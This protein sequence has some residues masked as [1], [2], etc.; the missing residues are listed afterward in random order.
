MNLHHCRTSADVP[1]GV[2]GNLDFIYHDAFNPDKAGVETLK[3][4]YRK[5]KVGDVEVKKRLA[6]AINDFLNPIRERRAHYAVQTGLVEKIIR[7][8]NQRMRQESDETMCR[9]R[10]AIGLQG[11]ITTPISK[12]GHAL[13]AGLIYC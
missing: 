10:E 7:H 11:L 8:G 1:G 3:D 6:Q 12:N 2:E 4:R 5:G 9:V 13:P